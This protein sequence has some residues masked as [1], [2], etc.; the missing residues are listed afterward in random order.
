MATISF[1]YRSEKPK[2]KLELRLLFS[3][4]KINYVFGTNTKIEVS[5]EQ[6]NKYHKK[7]PQKTSDVNILNTKSEILKIE[8]YILTEFEKQSPT[9]IDKNWLINIVDSYYNPKKVEAIPTDLISFFDYY[10][11]YRKNQLNA[12]S[13]MKYKTIQMKLKE[14]QAYRKQTILIKNVNEAFMNEFV[15]YYKS[16]NYAHNT[17]QREFSF[18]KTICRKA[19]FL[20]L[21][22]SH[23]LE[24]STIKPKKVESIYLTTEELNNI[25]KTKQD[26]LELENAKDWL[27]ISA[28]SGQRI[29]DFMR[30]S[31]DMIRT[32]NDQMYIEFKQKKTGKAMTVPLHTK[33][34][35]ILNKRDFNFPKKILDQ[36]YNSLI[37]IVCEKAK[38]NEI[39]FGGK[40]KDNRKVYDNYKKHELVTSHIGRR[41]FATNN[42]GIIPTSYLIYITG[43]KT[44]VM[45]LNYIGKNNKDLAIEV[46]KYFK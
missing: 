13:I 41:S 10:L 43:H 8:S 33:I 20:G 3:H 7:N 21:E 18:I 36:E 23:Q 34:I 29:S 42:Y 39:V 31:I 27:I 46:A 44:E 24:G 35:D 26:S 15:D 1:L 4:D 25:E 38:I 45:F 9:E 28:Y 22:V 40:Q 2:Q 32:E 6:W 16:K 11:N 12:P 5:K 37:K 30:F 19:R 17:T 14:F